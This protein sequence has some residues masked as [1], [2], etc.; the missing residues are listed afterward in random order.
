MYT[1]GTATADRF[2]KNVILLTRLWNPYGQS[3]KEELKDLHIQM[4]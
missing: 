2:V 4:Y 3:F 1:T